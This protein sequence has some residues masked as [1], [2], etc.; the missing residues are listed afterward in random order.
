MVLLCPSQRISKPF[1]SRGRLSGKSVVN[2]IAVN[3]S[4]G[5]FPCESG[6]FQGEMKS[7][8]VMSCPLMSW[9]SE[10]RN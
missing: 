8:F 6:G 2:G 3:G 9:P 4:W 7:H 1:E 5:I 10:T